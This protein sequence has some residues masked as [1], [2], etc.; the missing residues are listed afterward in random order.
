MEMGDEL[1]APV[2]LFPARGGGGVLSGPHI[3]SSRLEEEKNLLHVPGFEPPSQT[4]PTVSLHF[5]TESCPLKPRVGPTYFNHPKKIPPNQFKNFTTLL[6]GVRETACLDNLHGHSQFSQSNDGYAVRTAYKHTHITNDRATV[7]NLS[8]LIASHV[9]T[10][11]CTN[12]YFNNTSNSTFRF[13]IRFSIQTV[14]VCP[15]PALY[16]IHKQIVPLTI[17]P[18]ASY[19]TVNWAHSGRAVYDMGLRLFACWDCGFESRRGHGCLSHVSVVC[20]QVEVSAVG[21]SLVQRSPTECGVSECDREASI[22]RRPWPTGG[23]R[24]IRN[25]LGP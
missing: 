10:K 25:K 24:A 20:C 3:W 4:W 1:Q 12:I 9:L 21:C 8:H 6:R 5:K 17:L 19:K 15:T 7:H 22:M 2:T 14:Y 16:H 23:C 13:F 11:Q 18:T